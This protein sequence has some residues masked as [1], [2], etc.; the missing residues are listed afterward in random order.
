MNYEE[1]LDESKNNG[2][3][4]IENANFKSKSEGLINGDVIGI[5]R[6]IR[7]YKKR[8]CVLAEELGHYYTA[9][10]DIIDQSSSS[11]RKQELR[12]RAWSYNKLVGLNG[13]INAYKANHCSLYDMAEYL[14][15]TEE[16]LAEALS[17]YKSKYGLC[18]TL[19]N[20]IIYFE[21]AL[22][23]FQYIN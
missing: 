20:Y 10:G 16:F 12:G 17:Y 15:V 6:N 9:T 19:D 4:L 8:A 2:I 1:L 11:N 14:E 3:Y 7:S 22:G 18:T 23:V 21:P 13:I 5:N